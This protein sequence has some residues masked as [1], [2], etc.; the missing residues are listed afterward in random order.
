MTQTRSHSRECVCVCVCCELAWAAAS[1]LCCPSEEIQSIMPRL[2]TH[3][4][5]CVHVLNSSP[6]FSIYSESNFVFK[7]TPCTLH[8]NCKLDTLR[9]VLCTRRFLLASDQ[10]AGKKEPWPGPSNRLQAWGNDCRWVK[11][12]AF[13]TDGWWRWQCIDKQRFWPQ[14][15]KRRERTMY[16]SKG[17]N[18]DVQS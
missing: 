7:L 15:R 1:Y 16:V 18:W 13:V 4:L 14:Q 10:E 6:I 17:G 5:I 12:R 8:T 3:L 11:A 9:W 2:Q